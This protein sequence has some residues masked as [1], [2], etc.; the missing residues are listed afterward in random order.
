VED[1]SADG[2]A[3]LVLLEVGARLAVELR[4]GIVGVEDVVAD[5]FPG[6]AVEVVGAG[7]ADEVDVGAGAASISGVEVG[8]LN[9]ELFDGVG[10]GNGDA[11][12]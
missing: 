1:G 10:G 12:F 4:E 5:E 11:D 9:A 2:S 7:F 8:G 6:A 3:E